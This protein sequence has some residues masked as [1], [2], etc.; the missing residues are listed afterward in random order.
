M[1]TFPI[2]IL[3]KTYPREV[4]FY[5]IKYSPKVTSFDFDETA[6]DESFIFNIKTSIDDFNDFYAHIME[7][8]QFSFLRY[9][10]SQKTRTERDLIVGRALYRSCVKIEE[11]E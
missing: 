2:E 10:L 1:N 9:E 4:L 11:N 5:S 7:R 8:I 3:K 6:K